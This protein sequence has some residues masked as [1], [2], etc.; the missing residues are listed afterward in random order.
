M[1]NEVA[2]NKYHPCCDSS[3]EFN[4]QLCDS[5]VFNVTITDFLAIP[6]G[7]CAIIP[8]EKY[9]NDVT[10]TFVPTNVQWSVKGEEAAVAPSPQG[11]S[12]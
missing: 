11:S 12:S 2:C 8:L 6:A 9:Y 3:G 10:Y 1:C 4:S 7:K 5:S